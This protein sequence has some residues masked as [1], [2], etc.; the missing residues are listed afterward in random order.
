MAAGFF[1]CAFADVSPGTRVQILHT[2]P[3]A[4]GLLIRKIKAFKHVSPKLP[5]DTTVTPFIVQVIFFS[6]AKP[7]V[8]VG[9]LF[10]PSFAFYNLAQSLIGMHERIHTLYNFQ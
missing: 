4:L 8:S 3:C 2:R 5:G 9:F 7:R 10:S 1:T 6:F